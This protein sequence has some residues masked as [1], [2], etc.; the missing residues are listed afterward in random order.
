MHRPLRSFALALVFVSSACSSSI[1]G[2]NSNV[3]A[4]RVAPGAG[5]GNYIKHV[6]VIVQ[7]NRSFD[8]LFYC[9]PGTE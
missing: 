3:P 8:N 5:P 2:G 1:G 4:A 6:I 9:F 7:E